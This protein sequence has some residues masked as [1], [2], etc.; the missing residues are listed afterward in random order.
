MTPLYAMMPRMRRAPST[1][2]VLW[3]ATALTIAACG[4]DDT[5]GGGS[6]ASTYGDVS[7]FADTSVADASTSDNSTTDSSPADGATEDT[8]DGGFDAGC[9]V[10]PC[11]LQ[12][13][14]GSDFACVLLSDQTVRCWGDNYY[15][16][17]GAGTLGDGGLDTSPHPRPTAV[18][19]LGPVKE[20]A[21]G[22]AHACALLVDGTIWCWG[23][24]QYGQLAQPTDGGVSDLAP[25]PVKVNGISGTVDHLVA[26]GFHTCALLTDG[27]LSC[28][29]SNDYGQLGSGS[30][31]S[32]GGWARPTNVPT[33]TPA[34]V[35]GATQ[36]GLGSRF[37]CVLE[38]DGG[39]ACAGFN[40]DGQLGRG[41]DGGLT[42]TTSHP[43]FGLVSG[44]SGPIAKV[45]KS[46]GYHEIVILADGGLMAWGTNNYG[47]LGNED[48][49]GVSQPSAVSVVGFGSVL[50]VSP[51]N[52]FTCARRSDRTVWCWGQNARGVAGVSPEAGTPQYVP[53]QVAGLSNVT[54][55]SS[56]WSGFACAVIAGGNVECWGDNALSHL[57]RGP[58]AGVGGFDPSP[59]AIQY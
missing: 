17:I 54:Q 43:D 14:A 51:G 15:G 12:V 34:N 25:A 35:S 13:S 53:V 56:G 50:E 45:P 24:N 49:S 36:L 47:Q 40:Y 18:S 59:A 48:D 22:W 31:L 26:G 52:Y 32:D 58:D 5:S 39:I 8:S 37:T 57:G 20:L 9:T 10:S 7:S 42:D 21:S 16:E 38:S 41:P 44:L 11:A 46:N 2:L 33:P 27:T 55:I 3:T 1:L 29:G 6:D 4:S 23:S 28:W 19:G 30:F